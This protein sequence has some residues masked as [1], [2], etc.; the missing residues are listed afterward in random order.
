VLVLRWDPSS[1]AETPQAGLTY[2]VRVG[3]TPGGGDIVPPA[4]LP[5]GYRQIVKPGN[6]GQATLARLTNLAPGETYYWAVQAIDHSYAGSAFSEEQAVVFNP[7]GV[8]ADAGADLPVTFV[9]Q[10]NYPNPFNPITHV[11]FDLPDAS[12]VLQAYI[13]I[14]VLEID[15][16]EGVP[17]S[18]KGACPLEASRPVRSISSAVFIVKSEPKF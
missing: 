17:K 10:G 12:E 13:C 7:E 18:R 5:S 15:N 8:S 6:A 16:R 14:A 4:S 11:V 9:I 2:N 1:D 3:T